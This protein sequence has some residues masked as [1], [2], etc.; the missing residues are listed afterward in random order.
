[1][2]LKEILCNAEPMSVSLAII[3]DVGIG[4]S[5][6]INRLF[7]CEVA[8]VSS[9]PNSVTSG[10]ECHIKTFRNVNIKFYD[11]CGLNAHDVSR[12]KGNQIKNEIFSNGDAV[13]LL[14]F[15]FTRR[16]EDK[17]IEL[18]TELKKMPN[19]WERVVIVLTRGNYLPDDEHCVAQKLWTE[20][21]YQKYEIPSNVPIIA[22]GYKDKILNGMDWLSRVWLNVFK[23]S[24]YKSMV[25][26]LKL[27]LHRFLSNGNIFCLEDNL[28]SL[29]DCID[30]D[31]VISYPEFEDLPL[32]PIKEIQEELRAQLHEAK[33]LQSE[34]LREIQSTVAKPKEATPTEATPTEATPNKATP[35]E[36][37]PTPATPTPTEAT[38][39]EAT[40]KEATPT[41]ATP[42]QATLA[43]ATP[44]EA[45]TKDPFV[46]GMLTGA[47]A[48][49]GGGTAGAAVAHICAHHLSAQ[50]GT[51]G[52]LLSC[53]VGGA[54]GIGCAV[55]FYWLWQAHQKE[56]KSLKE[57]KEN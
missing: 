45:T 55:L 2:D 5:T 27:S 25:A 46:V 4:K 28:Q 23:K 22:A 36:A 56:E 43:E 14:C 39:T 29:Q 3:G 6:L 38:P 37:T 53:G 42:T 12:A 49:I 33:S 32:L 52:I 31:K 10:V 47:G 57:K 35:I 51:A 20:V 50:L 41:K 16:L 21:L 34:H 7:G 48:A 17:H 13:V 9:G 44:T 1:M 24:P 8:K 30:L 40:P 15:D 11:T 18:L 54:I 19:I 26:L